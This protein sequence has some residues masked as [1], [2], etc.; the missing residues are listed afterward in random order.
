MLKRLIERFF[1]KKCCKRFKNFKTSCLQHFLRWFLLIKN[2]FISH[3][4]FP[5]EQPA[6]KLLTDHIKQGRKNFEE[7]SFTEELRT[8]L[9]Y[10]YVPSVKSFGYIVAS[11]F[12]VWGIGEIF[13]KLSGIESPFPNITAVHAGIGVVIFALVIFVAE[14]LRDNEAKDKA[15][16][17]L[18]VSYLFP[19]VVAEI[20]V[21]LMLLFGGGDGIGEAFVVGVIG[22]FT[23][24]SLARIIN[25]LLSKRKFDEQRIN[26][27]QERLRQHME[28]AL[29][30]LLGNKVLS[31]ELGDSN[32][33][34]C[35]PSSLDFEYYS[36]YRR[37]IDYS[38]DYYFY[39]KKNGIIADIKFSELNEISTLMGKLEA[40]YSATHGEDKPELHSSGF[41]FQNDI[42][43]SSNA[44]LMKEFHDDINEKDR[45]LICIHK[46]LI[47]DNP[48]LL[49]KIEKHIDKAFTIKPKDNFGQEVRDEISGIKDQLIH[50]ITNKQFDQI[51][52]LSNLYIHLADSF[53][54]YIEKYNET[55]LK[56]ITKQELA[57]KV[58][59]SIWFSKSFRDVFNQ[60]MES[61]D[62]GIIRKV[63]TL[64]RI[65]SSRAI[66]KDNYNLFQEFIRFPEWLYHSAV[67]EKNEQL[68]KSLIE[69]S[70]QY[71]ASIY[72]I[73][74]HPRDDG[75]IEEA[76]HVQKYAVDILVIFHILL[77]RAFDYKDLDS[78]KKFQQV[79]ENFFV[80]NVLLKLVFSHEQR[81]EIKKRCDQMSFGLASWILH[82]LDRESNNEKN[83]FLNIKNNYKN[84]EFY[85]SICSFFPLDI[86]D[87]TTDFSTIWRRNI[88]YGELGYSEIDSTYVLG[89]IQKFYI[90]HLL[91]LLKDKDE[92]SIG[93]IKLPADL[94]SQADSL[95]HT[96]DQIKNDPD[97]YRFVLGKVDAT[98]IDLLKQKF[99]NK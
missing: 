98:K 95:I 23:L 16:V 99:S 15:R 46:D 67:K 26:L 70:W 1:K 45:R 60:T 92:K 80:K 22:L 6:P 32:I 73:I 34:L 83:Q 55:H 2:F 88:N 41:I 68:K 87:F 28:I 91:F 42:Q 65:M 89:D 82:L 81:Q 75:N 56:G 19:L 25:V 66:E 84:K 85:K 57:N 10:T 49:E 72:R 14:S 69:W 74:D 63:D 37:L 94:E 79:V 48:E 40:N 43:V 96:L 62:T 11:V 54:E 27:L 9:S 24:Y 61:H 47:D 21:F 90:V 8:R 17:L 36:E 44:Y 35:T 30:E 3:R 86:D 97:R 93:N 71:L 4:I 78:F 39:A 13:E 51:D 31:S 38:K 7:K 5:T 12:L 50:A 76:P 59:Q 52:R 29:K 77:K 58:E 33:K 20:I 53:S 18:K 64:A